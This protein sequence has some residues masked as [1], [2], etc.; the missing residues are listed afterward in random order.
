V[1]VSSFGQEIKTIR[2]TLVSDSLDVSAI[3]VVNKTSGATTISN[4][5]GGFKLAARVQDTLVFSAVHIKFQTL[6]L[7]E[8]IIQQPELNIYIEPVVN[9]LSEVVVKPHDL[10]GNLLDDIAQSPP[11]PI[12]FSDVGIPGFKGERKE[13]IRYSSTGKVLLSAVLLPLSPLDIEGVYKQISGYNKRLRHQRELKSRFQSVGPIISFYGPTFLMDYYHIAEDEV[14]PFVLGC[15]EN[16]PSVASDF[17]NGHHE[18][19]LQAMTNHKTQT[20]TP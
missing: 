2:G 9:E 12:N 18:L 11:P 1:G 13:K 16:F 6:I 17:K 20:I 3:H 19:V 8:D 10:S 15:L 5:N 14:Y 4:N 7:N